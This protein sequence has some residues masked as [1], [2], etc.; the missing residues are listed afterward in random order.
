[1]RPYDVLPI[2]RLADANDRF[3]SILSHLVCQH[4]DCPTPAVRCEI[5]HIQSFA[6]GGPTEP[7]NL[8][9]LC[10]RHNLLNDDNPDDIRHGHVF[11]DPTTGLTWY[12]MPDGR[13]RR[14]R[15]PANERALTA[16]CARMCPEALIGKRPNWMP[17]LE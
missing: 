2:K 12:Q 6:A 4:P 5:H 15:H 14:N 1:M 10:R 11:T 16:Y 9:P 17:Q 3:I 8:C 7:A 13:I